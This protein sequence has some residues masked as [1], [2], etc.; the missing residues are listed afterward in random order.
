MEPNKKD[1]KSDKVRV[2]IIWIL[3]S[4]Y[5]VVLSKTKILFETVDTES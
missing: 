2:R 3:V 4:P 5:K 1:L